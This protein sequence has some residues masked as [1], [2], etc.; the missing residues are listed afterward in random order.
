MA[1]ISAT[2]SG[3]GFSDI[4]ETAGA[5]AAGR[6]STVKDGINVT[7]VGQVSVL[8]CDDRQHKR[9]KDAVDQGGRGLRRRVGNMD[10][11]TLVV[12][13]RNLH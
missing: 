6:V 4:T 1:T 7:A 2:G 5:S 3:G 11:D 13:A 12:L 9:G 10:A 8:T